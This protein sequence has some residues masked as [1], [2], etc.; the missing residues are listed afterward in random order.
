MSKL[1]SILVEGWS[2][3]SS[4]FTKTVI[5]N[6]AAAKTCLRTLCTRR[7]FGKMYVN[8]IKSIEGDRTSVLQANGHYNY[9]GSSTKPG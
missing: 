1:L 7:Q 2:M 9:L 4:K 8:N 3:G 6:I 5:I